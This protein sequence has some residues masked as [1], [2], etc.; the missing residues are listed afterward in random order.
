MLS[1][2]TLERVSVAYRRGYLDG[3]NETNEGATVRPEC[4]LPFAEGD[5]AKG[6]EAGANDR[7]WA[8]RSSR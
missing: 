2:A 6:F 1:S 5:Y 8:S 7:R 4:F 3:Y